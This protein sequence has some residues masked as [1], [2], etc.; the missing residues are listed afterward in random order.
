MPK[1]TFTYE[2]FAQ[3]SSEAMLAKFVE[4]KTP[5]ERGAAISLLSVDYSNYGWF[6]VGTAKV[7]VT[8][9]LPADKILAASVAMLHKRREDVVAEFTK[10]LKEIDDSISKLQAI[11]YD[12]HPDGFD[13]TPIV[14]AV[15]G[16]VRQALSD[17]APETVEILENQA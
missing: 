7:T 16:G 4:A 6:A 2:Q 12:A 8:V 5:E 13:S 15:E 11:G 3:C 10:S 17:T 14:D 9:D 1:L